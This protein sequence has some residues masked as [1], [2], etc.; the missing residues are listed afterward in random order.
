MAHVRHKE[1]DRLRA[2]A[3]ELR[4]LGAEVEERGDGLRIIPGEPRGAE[5]ETYDDHRMAMSMAVAGL[6]VPGVAI[7]DPGCTAKTYPGFFDDL[8]RLT[9]AS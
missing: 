6:R 3:T 5:I 1:T 2:V 9:E 4:K 7:R 8:K